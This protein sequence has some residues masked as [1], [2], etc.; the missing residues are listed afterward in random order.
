MGAK[1]GERREEGKADVEERI[2][3]ARHKLQVNIRHFST[4]GAGS[5][6]LYMATG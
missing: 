1:W 6:C 5:A 4:R 2:T 3:R